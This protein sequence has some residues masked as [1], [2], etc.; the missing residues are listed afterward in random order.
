MLHGIKFYK[1]PETDILE[2]PLSAQSNRKITTIRYGKHG[3]G[4]PT[5]SFQGPPQAP[6]KA[7]KGTYPSY[8][9]LLKFPLTFS[10][11]RPIALSC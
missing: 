4:Y 1:V 6:L 2:T 11:S 7:Q 3:V 8:F 10:N 9:K 5:P